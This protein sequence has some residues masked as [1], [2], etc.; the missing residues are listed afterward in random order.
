MPNLYKNPWFHIKKPAPNAKVRLFCFPYAGGSAQVFQSWH[1]SLPADIEVI[2]VQYPGRNSRFADPLIS[3]CQAMVEALLPNILPTL[4]KPFVFFGHS[5][6]GMMS[7]ELARALQRKGVNKQ[8]HHFISAKRAIHLPSTGKITHNLPDKEFLSEIEDLGGTPPEILA[9]RELMELFM[10][11]LRSDFSVS[12]TFKYEGEDKLNTNA[13]LLYGEQD[14]GVPVEDVMRWQELI[15]KPADSVKFS[16]GHFFINSQSEQLLS[17][18]NT[19]L[20]GILQSNEL[21][22]MA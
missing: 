5:N 10:P 3:S 1:E 21:A 14:D 7:F 22:A 9:N 13:T 17:L 2:G 12:E 8:L 16:G 4:N 15:E 19:R 11:V 18:L 20:N 6:G